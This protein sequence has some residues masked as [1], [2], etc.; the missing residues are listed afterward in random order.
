MA[1]GTHG[2]PD[3][4][5]QRLHGVGGVNQPADLRRVV[6]ERDHLIP[7]PTPTRRDSRMAGGQIALRELGQRSLC[8]L[9]IHG[10]VDRLQGCRHRPAVLVAGKV[11]GVPACI[12]SDNGPEFVAQAVQEWIKAVGAKTAYIEPG[13]PWENGYC[14]RLKCLFEFKLIK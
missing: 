8:G 12:R 1:A 4:R 3:F 7:S 9:G 6:Q 2:A 13:S 10:R 11:H 5:V 14:G